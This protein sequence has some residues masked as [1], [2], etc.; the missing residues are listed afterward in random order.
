MPS[1]HCL[2][3]NKESD[4]AERNVETDPHTFGLVIS[5]KHIKVHQKTFLLTQSLKKKKK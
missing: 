3:V 4:I 2:K 5:G 1:R